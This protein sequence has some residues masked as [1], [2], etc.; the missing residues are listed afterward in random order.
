MPA[1]NRF[2]NCTYI[3]YSS[4]ID[5]ED[6]DLR[7]AV[8]IRAAAAATS[9]IRIASNN[10]LQM[11]QESLDAAKALSIARGVSIQKQQFDLLRL[12]HL[13]FQHQ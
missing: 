3:P 6:S 1:G 8:I 4:T 2:S 13:G 5:S 12:I 7:S 10:P 11:R 9:K